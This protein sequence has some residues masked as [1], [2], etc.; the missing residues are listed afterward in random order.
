MSEAQL[1][2]AWQPAAPSERYVSLDLLRGVALF[3][4]LLVNLAGAFRV[5]LFQHILEFHTHPGWASHLTDA[6]VAG[7]LE[8]KA[9]TLFSFLF[10]VGV[11]IQ[12]ERAAP[13][14]INVTLFLVRRFLVLLG[15]GLCHMFLIW[16]GDILALYAVCG[17]LLVPFLRLPA[18]A[19]LLLG[20]AAIALPNFVPLGVPWPSAEALRANVAEAARVYGPRAAF[21]QSCCFAGA[22]HGRLS[23]RC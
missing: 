13:K 9:L 10:G 16:N 6:L 2:L 7:V 4:V 12:V 21:K 11:A 20:A 5:S 8:F 3:G 14:H 23:C 15:L 19:L 17:L 1:G 18:W 22:K